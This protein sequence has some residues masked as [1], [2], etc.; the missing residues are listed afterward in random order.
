MAQQPQAQTAT[1]Q[2]GQSIGVGGRFGESVPQE[3]RSAV[4]DLER[5]ETLCEWLA[6]RATER[7]APQIAGRA[8]DIAHLAHVQKRLL[9]RNSPFAGPVGRAIQQTVGSVLGEFQQRSAD[10]EVQEAIGQIQ[11]TVQSLD[12]ALGGLQQ[13]SAQGW[14]GQSQ[15]TGS[16][17]PMGTRPQYPPTQQTEVQPPAGQMGTQQPTTGF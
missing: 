10:P 14:Y 13:P 11:Q 8:D 5:V 12:R 3:V 16:Q 2:G 17:Q 6:D 15:S 4:L 1:G 9:L 7:G